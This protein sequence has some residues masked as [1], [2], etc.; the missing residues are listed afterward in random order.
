MCISLPL[1]ILL[2]A[3]NRHNILS[4]LIISALAAIISLVFII[5]ATNERNTAIIDLRTA[6]RNL[7]EYEK[8][9]NARI[10]AMA[11]QS[12]AYAAK[13]AAKHPKCPVCGSTNT[14]RI[15]TLN[16][17]VSIATLGLASSKIGKQY[18]CKNCKHKW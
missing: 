16:R 14:E 8:N 2:L 9:P 12:Q 17:T 3:L 5:S 6:K 18:Q 10:A 4:S 15:S 7:D 13:N 1:T 11:A